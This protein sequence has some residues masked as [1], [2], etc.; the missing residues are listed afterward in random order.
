MPDGQIV[1]FIDSF[2]E[3]KGL[4]SAGL[5]V[6]LVGLIWMTLRHLATYYVAHKIQS[7]HRDGRV[8]DDHPE[9]TQWLKCKSIALFWL[10]LTALVVIS[11]GSIRLYLLVYLP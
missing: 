5:V 8:V 2:L 7:A 1:S 10:H 9:I 4:L 3:Y 11:Y 6:F